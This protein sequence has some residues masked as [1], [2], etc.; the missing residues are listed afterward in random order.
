MSSTRFAV[1]VHVLAVLAVHDGETLPS[2]FL[3]ESVNTNPTF[4]RHVL[5]KLRKARLVRCTLGKTGG[6]RLAQPARS[7]RLD[8]VYRATESQ[9]AVAL[10]HSEPDRSCPVGRDIR[11]VLGGITT[12]AQS[13]LLRELRRFTVADV[14]A[15]LRRRA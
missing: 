10:H 6:A 2:A 9:P 1:G 8:R 3:A 14:V 7:I 15:G 4:I 13:S 12:R 11:R 5:G